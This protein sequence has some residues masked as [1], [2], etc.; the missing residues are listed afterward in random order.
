MR[1]LV[2]SAPEGGVFV[3]GGKFNCATDGPALQHG[4]L[5]REGKTERV[6]H[7]AQQNRLVSLRKST[8]IRWLPGN[9]PFLAKAPWY[10]VRRRSAYRTRR[11]GA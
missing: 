9:R 11:L 6:K 4:Q 8:A 2:T 10:P 3:G 1:L 5:R 7:R